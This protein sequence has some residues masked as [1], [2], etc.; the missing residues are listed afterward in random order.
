MMLSDC[1]T[2]VCLMWL[3]SGEIRVISKIRY[4]VVATTVVLRLQ[5]IVAKKHVCDFATLSQCDCDFL[6]DCGYNFYL[7]TY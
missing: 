4:S 1:L 3:Q 2:C 7:L 5:K 6:V